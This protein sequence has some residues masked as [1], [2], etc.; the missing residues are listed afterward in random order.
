MQFPAGYVPAG[1]VCAKIA[2]KNPLV[3]VK[4]YASS[5]SSKL[6]AYPLPRENKNLQ[7]SPF[8]GLRLQL[9]THMICRHTNKI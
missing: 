8:R 7:R 4:K 3:M 9:I 1:Y 6:L 5:T 2:P